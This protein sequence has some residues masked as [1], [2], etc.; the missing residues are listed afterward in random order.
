MLKPYIR[1]YRWESPMKLM[2][3]LMAKLKTQ[4]SMVS[5]KCNLSNH[6]LTVLTPKTTLP[7]AAAVVESANHPAPALSSVV[8]APTTTSVLITAARP[9]PVLE[10]SAAFSARR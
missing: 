9:T 3:I 1:I 8:P 7:T 5:A 6:L 2:Q 10:G 4:K